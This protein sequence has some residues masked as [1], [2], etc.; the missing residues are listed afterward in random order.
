MLKQHDIYVILKIISLR[1]EK[2]VYAGLSE[3]LLM[4]PSETNAA[5]KRASESGLMR[6][7]LGAEANPQP[8]VAAVLEFLKHGMRYVFPAR[9]GGLVRGVPTG[10]AAPGLGDVFAETGESVAVWPWSQGTFRGHSLNP[11]FRCAPDAVQNAPRFH[12]YLALAD[13]LRQ[14]S[15]RGREVAA[16]RLATMMEE[17]A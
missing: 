11:L 8:I 15:P 14:S 9:V 5:V 10:F 12:T 7:A 1:R 16:R 3:A 2:W 6:P 4:S 17:D 13:V